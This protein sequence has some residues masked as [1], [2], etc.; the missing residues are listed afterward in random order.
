MVSATH[1]HTG[2]VLVAAQLPADNPV[3]KSASEYVAKYEGV[4]GKGSVNAFGGYAWD[5]GILLA[6]AAPGALKKAQPGSKEFRAALRDAL[7]PKLRGL[8]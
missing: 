2:P 7:D 6:N 5:A 4:H 8:E 1:S 3:K